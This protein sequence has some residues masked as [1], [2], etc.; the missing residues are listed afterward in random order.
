MMKSLWLILPLIGLTLGV[1]SPS[2][3]C[4]SGETCWPKASD[5]SELAS[6]L[7]QPLLHPKPP[8]SACYPAD[9]PSGNCSD[10]MESVHSGQWRS[11]QPGSMQAPFLETFVFPNG[12][13]DACYVNT[14]LGFP[15]RQGSIPVIGVDAQS[16]RDVQTAIRFTSTHN[17]RLVIKNTGRINFSHDYLG[18]STARGS[19]VLWT[20]NLKNITY[21]PSFVPSGAPSGKSYQAL[22]VGAGVQWNEAYDAAKTHNRVIVGGAG[23]TVG[24]AG[25]WVMGGGHGVLAPRH[26][27]GVDNVIE[28]EVVTADGTHLTVNAFKNTDLFWALRGGGG[29]TYAI[30]LL[31]TYATHDLV[32]L[33]VITG[34]ANFTSSAVAKSVITEFMK[35]HP[36]LADDGWGSYAVL[37]KDMLQYIFAAPNVTSIDASSILDPFF[38]FMRNATGGQGVQNDTTHYDSFYA[39]NIDVFGLNNGVGNDFEIGSRFI[40]RSLAEQDP[41][42]VADIMLTFPNGVGINFIAG[43]AV[44]KVDPD[45]TGLHPDWRKAIGLVN[46]SEG[47]VDGDPASVIEA[48]RKKIKEGLN[49]LQGLGSSTYFNGLKVIKDKY[50]PTGLFLVAGGVG[51]E[52]WDDSLNCRRLVQ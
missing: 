40:P 24:A 45:S 30:V 14:T 29:G 18:R 43:G 23:L 7:S 27:L 33:T 21:D 12:T 10:V 47:W 9:N 51:S 41:E 28:F 44:S 8:G 26:G 36:S 38:T 32:P 42:K 35:I 17:L 4:L 11:D 1:P 50:D 52:D 5:F 3:R 48:A 6:Q 19:F 25:G 13:I 2:C 20:H 46:F 39:W 22:T 16:V 31:A 37:S 34:L 15:C 49:I